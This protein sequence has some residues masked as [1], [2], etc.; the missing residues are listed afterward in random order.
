MP[1][2]GVRFALRAAVG[3]AMAA[4]TL[5]AP[6][7]AAAAKQG[8]AS[9]TTGV[10]IGVLSD[11]P[12]TLN[13]LAATNPG[14]ISSSVVHL[15]AEDLSDTGLVLRPFDLLAIDDFATD[16]LTAAQRAALVDY[17]VNGGSLLLGTGGAW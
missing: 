17:V 6:T 13:A 16:T 12:A 11:Q 4:A 1:V 8:T 15:A 3:F 14:G 7:A 2:T 5:L 10:L 9:N